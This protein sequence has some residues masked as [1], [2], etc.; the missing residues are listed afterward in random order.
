MARVTQA[1]ALLEKGVGEA[2]AFPGGTTAVDRQ[3]LLILNAGQGA[4]MRSDD[5]DRDREQRRRE[6]EAAA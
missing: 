4:R 1:A 5:L 3:A 6:A 2:T